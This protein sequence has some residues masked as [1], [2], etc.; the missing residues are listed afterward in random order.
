[1]DRYRRVYVAEAQGVQVYF[2]GRPLTTLAA[3]ELG[4]AEIRDLRIHGND[5]AIADGL[6]ARVHLLRVLPP[7]RGS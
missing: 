3:R 1:M 4:A 5:L 6:G 2:D 7:G